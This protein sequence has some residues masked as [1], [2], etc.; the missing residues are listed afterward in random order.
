MKV[1]IF[2]GSGYLGLHLYQNL[3]DKNYDVH[4]ATRKKSKVEHIATEKIHEIDIRNSQFLEKFLKKFDVVIHLASPNAKS[5]SE[6]VIE[7]LKFHIEYTY[8]LAKASCYANIKKFIYLSTVHVYGNNLKGTID[9]ANAIPAPISPYAVG[10]KF[11]EDILNARNANCDCQFI[12]LRASNLFGSPVSVNSDCWDLLPNY[13]SRKI[14]EKEVVDIKSKGRDFRDFLPI[15]IACQKIEEI[16][17]NKTKFCLY[18]LVSG[19]MI[20]I[21]EMINFI[22]QEA[23]KIS[24]IDIPGIMIP[25]NNHDKSNFKYSNKRLI[26]EFGGVEFNFSDYLFSTVINNFKLLSA[27]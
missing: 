2:G 17:R 14:F 1:I 15:S 24:G 8:Q 19:N 5:S 13:L 25:I 6:A 4:I 10:H 3:K 21:F 22:N 20:N 7:S 12:I 26:A 9:E 18:N 27:K 23:K 16:I 11:S